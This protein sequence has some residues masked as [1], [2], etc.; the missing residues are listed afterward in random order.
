[1]KILMVNKFFYP[2]GGTESYVINLSKL[3][4]NKGH[5]VIPFGMKHEQNIKGFN[6]EDFVNKI[7]YDTS[8]LR[9][10]IHY[11]GKI[12]YSIEAKKKIRKVIKETKPDIAHLHNIYHQ[13]SPSIL[14][15]LKKFNIPMVMTAHD[16]KFLCPNYKLYH[17][18]NICEK[19]RVLR[20]YHAIIGRC[21]KGSLYGSTLCALEMYLHKFLHLYN[22]IQKI[23]CPSLFYKMKFIQFGFPSEKLIHIP[24]F[25][26]TTEYPPSNNASNYFIFLGRLVS[27][28]GLMTL[29]AAMRKIKGSE[30]YIIGEG[31]ARKELEAEATKNGNDNIKFLGFQSGKKLLSL[32]SGAMFMVMPSEWYENCPLSV[33]EAFSAGKPVI[34]ANVGGLPEIVEDGVNGLLFKMGDADDLSEKILHL[35]S[36]PNKRKEIGRK[37]RETV[38]S[39]YNLE[40]HYKRIMTLYNSLTVNVSPD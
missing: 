9:K 2:F 24:N 8:S 30:L 32:I 33:L 27:E 3:L 20:F 35:I 40:L 34:A 5:Q 17:N 23:I 12:L 21:V 15:E 36:N 31:S 29:I 38:V 26:S 19:C 39:N 13:L 11:A 14:G 10:K 6:S 28:K 25:V 37:A 1:M 16:L 22:N 18:G 7:D 4:L